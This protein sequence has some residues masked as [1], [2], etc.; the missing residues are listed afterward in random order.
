MFKLN[1]LTIEEK[2]YLMTVQPVGIVGGVS[3]YEH[4]RYGEDAPLIIEVE[5]EWWS[6]EYYE[7][8]EA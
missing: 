6:T 4:P 8:P 7:L 2:A 5:N 1:K 3:Y